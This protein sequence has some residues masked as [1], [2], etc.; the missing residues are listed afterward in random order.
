MK[1]DADSLVQPTE[2]RFIHEMGNAHWHWRKRPD[3]LE[4]EEKF[5]GEASGFQLVVPQSD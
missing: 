4:V 5:E 2:H 1:L 3:K